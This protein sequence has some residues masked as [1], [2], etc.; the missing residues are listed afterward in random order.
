MTQPIVHDANSNNTVRVLDV[1]CGQ[2]DIFSRPARLYLPE[3]RG[4]LP[5]LLDVHG[6]AWGSGGRTDNEKIDMALAE[7][8]LLVLAVALRRAPEHAYPSQVID[9]N[10]ATRWLKAHAGDYGAAAGCIGGLGTSSGG[11]TLFL[12]TMR[13]GD[14]RYGA[15]GLPEGAGLDARLSYLIAAWPVIDPYGRYLFAREK[16]LDFLVE[17]TDHYFPDPDV[18]QEGNPLLALER[19]ELLDLPPGLFI[20]GTADSNVPL[21]SVNRFD[22]AYRAAGGALEMVWFPDMPHGFACKPGAESDRAIDIMKNF[23][24]RQLAGNTTVGERIS[25]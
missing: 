24:S 23:I 25:S 15:E 17:R 22:E 12:S 18:M 10:F 3:K 8:G 5:A 6:G 7:S 21:P 20:Q 1:T 2:D 16:G 4:P 14:A 13:P 19:G 9:V 11:H